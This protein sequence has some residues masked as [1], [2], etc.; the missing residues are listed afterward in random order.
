MENPEVNPSLPKVEQEDL[1]AV[2]LEG[3]LDTHHIMHLL[4]FYDQNPV[5]YKKVQDL[6]YNEIEQSRANHEDA[7]QLYARMLAIDAISIRSLQVALERERNKDK[8]VSNVDDDA[9]QQP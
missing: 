8:G 5:L 1:D 9:N 2:E 7:S 6:I 4:Y 3:I